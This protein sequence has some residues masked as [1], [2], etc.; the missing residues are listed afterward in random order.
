MDNFK[1]SIVA[2]MMSSSCVFAG[3]DLAP[4]VEPEVVIPEPVIVEP[5]LTGF[6]AGLGYSCLQTSYDVPYLDM[7]AMTALSV[8]AGYN[9]NEY[10]AVEGR[11]TGSM[12]DITVKDDQGR[13]VDTDSIDLQN[14]GIYIK[15]QYSIESFGLYALLGYGQFSLDNGTAYSEASIQY[16]AG[17]NAQVTTNIGLFVDYRRLYDDTAFD[18]FELDRDVIANSYTIGVNYSF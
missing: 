16:G 8:T 17:I 18:T 11:Y 13:E 6:Y 1:K 12:G 9:F 5:E 3:G 10:L 7:R 14:I 15:P 2:L 4:I